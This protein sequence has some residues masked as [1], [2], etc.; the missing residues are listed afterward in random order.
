M[1]NELTK[2]LDDFKKD[3]EKWEREGRN[4]GFKFWD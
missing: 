2:M 1:K 3:D 4:L